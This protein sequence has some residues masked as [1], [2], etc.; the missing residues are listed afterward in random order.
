[1]GAARCTK[2]PP[3]HSQRIKWSTQTGHS[4]TQKETPLLGVT[5]LL[6]MPAGMALALDHYCCCATQPWQASQ[7]RQLKHSV[8]L[9]PT[10]QLQQQN[11]HTR[12]HCSVAHVC[13][14]SCNSSTSSA[15]TQHDCTTHRLKARLLG[16]AQLLCLLSADQL[17]LTLPTTTSS[18]S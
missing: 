18:M 8:S 3:R 12:S 14:V 11:S 9:L 17:L 13:C 2:H 10:P 4:L 7:T 15:V 6:G 1:M 16:A 5:T